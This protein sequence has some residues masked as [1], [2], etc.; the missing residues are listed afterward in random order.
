MKSL[1]KKKTTQL[2]KKFTLMATSQ[3][4]RLKFRIP[5]TVFSHKLEKIFLTLSPPLKKNPR[6]SFSMVAKYLNLTL[7]TLLQ[8]M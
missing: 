5:S 1:G 4:I 3:M 6:I 7:Q 2:L 8:N